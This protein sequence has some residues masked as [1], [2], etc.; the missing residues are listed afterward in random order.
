MYS[1]GENIVGQPYMVII[2]FFISGKV[3]LEGGEIQLNRYYHI[4]GNCRLII[5]SEPGFE[6]KLG[7]W[8]YKLGK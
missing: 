1:P 7:V 3:T 5:E 8:A 4:Y 6:G 2:P